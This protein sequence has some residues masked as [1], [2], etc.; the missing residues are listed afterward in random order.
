[1]KVL[2]ALDHSPASRHAARTAAQLLGPEGAELLALNVTGL[3]LSWS[4]VGYGFGAV[5][6]LQI[7]AL[8]AEAEAEQTEA[9]RREALAAGLPDAEVEI[10]SGDV[11][12]EICAAA[13]RH[14]VD[15]IVVGSHD[16]GLLSRLVEPSVSQGVVR[17]STRPVLVVPEVAA[18]TADQG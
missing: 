14:E 7:G 5:I 8:D 9:M 15:L 18:E 4:G 17:S 12:H 11:V 1:M 6:P 16:R 10:A 13:D 2:I 3:P